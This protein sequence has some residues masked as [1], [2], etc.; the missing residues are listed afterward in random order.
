MI[1]EVTGNAIES[2]QPL[3]ISSPPQSFY[4]TITARFAIAAR[5]TL[6]LIR[7]IATTGII[8]LKQSQLNV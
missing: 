3:P 4:R 1:A 8:T 6:P 5:F 7:S 2:P